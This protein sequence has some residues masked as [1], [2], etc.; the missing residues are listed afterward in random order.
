M[1]YILDALKR[2]DAERERGQVPGL[3]AQPAGPA[4]EPAG[5]AGRWIWW[6]GGAA[7]AAAGLVWWRMAPPSVGPSPSVQPPVA[8]VAVAPMAVTPAPA[9]APA[10]APVV[11]P[12]ARV[13]AV[14]A[15]PSPMAVRPAG[16]SVSPPAPAPAPVAVPAAGAPSAASAASG[17]A[18]TTQ[19]VYAIRELPDDVRN[20][21]PKLSV[22]GSVYSGNAAQRV[23]ILNG[24]VFTEGGSPA[25]DLTI[26]RIGPKA[27]VMNF[28]GTR[29]T[30]DY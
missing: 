21:L 26:E 6:L 25:P 13:A 22:S 16:A 3:N 24:Q 11:A 23:L 14:P 17:P 20:A 19:R 1:S 18:T 15:P 2:A 7:I 30:L 8:A 4:G 5:G 28:R 10:P 29:Y 27:A 12:A 9:P